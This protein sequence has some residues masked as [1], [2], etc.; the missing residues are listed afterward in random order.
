MTPYALLLVKPNDPDEVIRKAYHAQAETQ[1][2]D[3]N[4]GTPGPQWYTATAAYNAIK[5]ETLRQ[6]WARRQGALAGLCATCEGSGVVGTRMFKGK[7]RLC[8][9]CQ[10]EGRV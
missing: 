9:G 1:H 4:G 10:G 7:I 6:A 2:P 3:A 5:T 8:N